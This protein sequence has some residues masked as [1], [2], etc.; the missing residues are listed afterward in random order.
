MDALDL[1]FNL[2]SLAAGGYCL[3]TWLRLKKEK[4]VFVNPL[5]VPKDAKPTDCVDAEA[6]LRTIRPC[7]LFAGLVWGLTG[8]VGMADG[9]VHFFTEQTAFRFGL[10]STA[11]CIV[12][13]AVYFIVWLR[14]RKLYWVL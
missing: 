13:V 9:F 11:A 6:Y 5:L 1:Y 10:G 8:L 14:A 3:Y 12:A 7:L 4:T 2:I